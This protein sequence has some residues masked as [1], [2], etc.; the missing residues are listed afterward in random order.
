MEKFI[1]DGSRNFE[2]NF[3]RWF[4]LNCEERSYY[5]DTQYTEEHGREVFAELVKKQWQDKRKK[6]QLS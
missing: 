4:I 2:E 3:Q 1:Y 6:S 5:N